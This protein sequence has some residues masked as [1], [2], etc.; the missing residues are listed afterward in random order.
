MGKTGAKNLDL[1]S[2]LS[3]VS[4]T[5]ANV[6]KYIESFKNELNDFKSDYA[7]SRKGPNSIKMNFMII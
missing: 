7:M 3:I 6:K 5:I 1:K 4:S 2:K